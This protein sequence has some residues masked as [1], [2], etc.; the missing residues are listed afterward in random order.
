MKVVAMIPSRMG[1]WR[2]PGKPLCD[3]CGL[4]MI[5]HVYKRT[6]MSKSLD[7]TYMVTCN[8]EIED[9][10]KKFGGKVIM[11]PDTFNRCTDRIAYAVEES[12]CDA[13]IIV[14]VQGD[15]PLVYP[16]MIDDAVKPMLKD[17]SIVCGCLISK[18]ES[19]E[20][21]DDRNVIKVVKDN[22]DFALYLSREGIPSKRLYNKPFD[23]YKQVCIMP[24]R[25]DFLLKFTKLPQTPLET[26]ESVDMLRILEHGYKIKLVETHF[27]SHSVDVEA[28]RDT[29]I[30]LMEQDSLFPKYKGK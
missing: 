26:V 7:E 17:E 10:T 13:D 25:R 9:A 18:V 22:N 1:S 14:V 20:E 29:V 4:S 23:A 11:T 27:K 28:D 2:F 24:Y 21:F 12:G 5:E 30:K 8:K 3:I 16:Q 6:A 15:E 19:P